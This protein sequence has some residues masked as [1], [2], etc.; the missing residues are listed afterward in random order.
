MDDKKLRAFLT[1]VRTGSLNKAAEEIGYTQ[2]GL[3]QM[4]NSLE[5]EVGCK[6]LQ[7]SNKGIGLTQEGNMLL[8]YVQQA[9][10]ALT[11]LE[12]EI[13]RVRQGTKKPLRIGTYASI[14]RTWLP[15]MLQGFRTLHPEI[16]IEVTVG[17]RE[18]S[19]RL[20]E[21][22]ID[23]AFVD[24]QLANG[25]DWIPI[26]NAPLVAVVPLSYAA[27]GPV[28]LDSLLNGTFIT[29]PEQYVEARISPNTGA[30]RFKIDAADD[31][32]II[33]MVETGLGVSVLCTL[34]LQGYAHRV[35]TLPLE[36]PMQCSF[37][38]MVKS[39]TAA[40]QSVRE[41]IHYAQELTLDSGT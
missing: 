37:G 36:P 5:K 19:Q 23:V 31:A 34:S 4:M 6:L 13:N 24:E 41:L 25:F 35:R 2:P 9:S 1:V 33:S 27:D 29:A 14:S 8:S 3:T 26:Q 17:G 7:R 22:V 28:K 15:K 30:N 10:D 40:P 11:R 16:P 12:E 21:N 20:M 32:S 18:L 38:L 39:R